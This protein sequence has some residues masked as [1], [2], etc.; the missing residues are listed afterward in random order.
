[1]LAM[2]YEQK[3]GEADKFSFFARGEWKHLRRQYFD[4]ANTLVQNPYDIYNSNLSLSYQDWKI[5]LWARNIFDT[6]YISHGYDFGAVR[7]GNPAII[8]ILR[9]PIYKLCLFGLQGHFHHWLEG[10]YLH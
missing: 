7:L 2:Q 3:F 6:M 10:I 5:T 4:L 1:M 9:K 8:I